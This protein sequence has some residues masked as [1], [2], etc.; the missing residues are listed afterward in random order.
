MFFSASNYTH[1]H[2]PETEG[3][4]TAIRRP[5]SLCVG[6]HFHKG[7]KGA[8]NSGGRPRCLLCRRYEKKENEGLA[9]PHSTGP[10][11]RSQTCGRDGTAELEKHGPGT[12][13]AAATSALRSS[14]LLP[15]PLLLLLLLPVTLLAWPGHTSQRGTPFG[16]RVSA[17]FFHTGDS[18]KLPIRADR[19]SVV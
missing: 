5:Q 18:A 7:R 9:S 3:A 12:A 1:R 10:L 17:I 14:Y 16:R 4:T 13:G 8:N 6:K 11:R 2:H 15:P 19:K